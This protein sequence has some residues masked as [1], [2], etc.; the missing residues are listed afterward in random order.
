MARFASRVATR[1]REHADPE[2]V[3]GGGSQ[4]QAVDSSAQPHR[5]RR[6]CYKSLLVGHQEHNQERV[7]NNTD[8]S[9]FMWNQK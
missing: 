9:P 1:S 4:L 7:G 8:D 3:G 2:S 5:G 6:V